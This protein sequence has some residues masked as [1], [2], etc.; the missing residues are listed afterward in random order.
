M[1]DKLK[2]II[3]DAV[4]EVAE[5][6]DIAELK[7]INDGTVLMG[8]KGVLDSAALVFLVAALED[9]IESELGKTLTIADEAMFSRKSPFQNI[10]TLTDYLRFLLD[11]QG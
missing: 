8:E 9:K 11:K 3:Y 6:D 2:T 5:T 7:N 10:G 1:T 4:K